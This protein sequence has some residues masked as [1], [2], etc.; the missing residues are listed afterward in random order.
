MSKIINITI[1][2]SKFKILSELEKSLFTDLLKEQSLLEKDSDKNIYSD[3]VYFISKEDIT[4][5]I[6]LSTSLFHYASPSKSTNIDRWLCIHD[7]EEQFNQQYSYFA[8]RANGSLEYKLNT[9]LRGNKNV[10]VTRQK[11][12]FSG[13]YSTQY[14]ERDARFLTRVRPQAKIAK[15]YLT[16]SIAVQPGFGL[17]LQE[18]LSIDSVLKHDDKKSSSFDRDALTVLG[19]IW[20]AA[21]EL[22]WLFEEHKILHNDIK[23]ENMGYDYV[24]DRF[25]FFDFDLSTTILD[26][27]EVRAGS[28]STRAPE[29]INEGEGNSIKS[30]I[31]SLAATI[32]MIVRYDT[33]EDEHKKIIM[34]VIK[35]MRSYNAADRPNNCNELM[36][37]CEFIS[38]YEIL[39]FNKKDY[40]DL[41]YG[42]KMAAK[43]YITKAVD[44]IV[45]RDATV[46]SEDKEQVSLLFVNDIMQNA[47]KYRGLFVDKPDFPTDDQERNEAILE[48]NIKLLYKARIVEIKKELQDIK[49]MAVLIYADLSN[50]TA[51]EAVN[52]FDFYSV[53][54]RVS[55]DGEPLTNVLYKYDQFMLIERVIA[56]I[57]IIDNASL[58]ENEKIKL[59]HDLIEKISNTTFAACQ[60]KLS[61]NQQQP[62]T[63]KFV[64]ELHH[65]NRGSYVHFLSKQETALSAAVCK[66]IANHIDK[67]SCHFEVLIQELSDK[68]TKNRNEV[69][70]QNDIAHIDMISS[71]RNYKQINLNDLINPN[72]LDNFYKWMGVDDFTAE[73]RDDV[74]AIFKSKFYEWVNNID[75][76]CELIITSGLTVEQQGSIFEIFKDKF[77]DWVT[78]VNDFVELYAI[79]NLTDEQRSDIF[80]LFKDKFSDWVTNVND[81]GRLITVRDLT[82]KQRSDIFKLFKDKFSDWVTNV[83]NFNRLI[84]IYDYLPDEQRSDI[85]ELF[86]DKFSD[87]VTNVNDFDRLIAIHYL[88]DEQR[89]DIFKLFKD[90]FSDWVTNV[91]DFGRLITV[92]DLTDKQRSDIFK[93]FKDKFSDWVTNVNNFNRLITIYDLPDEQRS[94][95]FKLFKDKFSDWV[96]N[97]NDF[98]RLI[99]VRDLTDK[100][101]SDIFKLFKDKFSDWVT[102]INDFGR[103]IA[104]RDL[105]DEQRSDI[106]ELFK[107]KFSEWVTN[108]NNFDRLIAIHYLTDEQRSN[109]FD[110][111]KDK[112][113]NLTSTA[114]GFDEL[115]TMPYLTSKQRSYIFEFLKNKFSEIATEY[116]IFYN[117]IKLDLTK[118]QR[119]NLIGNIKEKIPN[120]IDTFQKAKRFMSL[121]SQL[122]EEEELDEQQANEV[123]TELKNKLPN[124]VDD[125][126]K[127]RELMK[128]SFLDEQQKSEIFAILKDE[129]P[130]FTNHLNDFYDIIFNSGLAEHQ[131]EECIAVFKESLP[132]YVSNKD[133]FISIM[134]RF[135]NHPC[136]SKIFDVLKNQLSNYTEASSDLAA[137]M[138]ADCLSEYKS[139]IVIAKLSS[140]VYGFVNTLSSVPGLAAQALGDFIHV[141]ADCV[142]QPAHFVGSFFS[143]TSSRRAET[144]SPVVN[145]KQAEQQAR[146]LPDDEGT[147]SDTSDSDNDKPSRPNHSPTSD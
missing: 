9:S 105:T 45:E 119:N 33:L 126:K 70:K 108:V 127:F 116:S 87:W 114:N 111:L 91:K 65:V 85:F 27:R 29:V 117:L 41:S 136:K 138:S 2:P 61:T 106:F 22:N 56:A 43:K 34:P 145:S 146:L 31:Y 104:I 97:V 67:N 53:I 39:F 44:S 5:Q 69:S 128:A 141:I 71:N 19:L 52:Q 137:L 42:T 3:R 72:K 23:L 93:L 77:S 99:T 109:I 113:T 84:A 88:T 143:R 50:L 37:M 125:P 73:Q 130:S 38:A 95:I 81:F 131:Q 124:L 64:N 139:E 40:D 18:Y 120:L 49:K 11:G 75:D 76:F 14:L 54:G 21:A 1:N 25:G 83:N 135:N 82:D 96:T 144:S 134:E 101:R 78:N 16:A 60:K 132:S 107:D 89:S 30:D 62:I 57:K 4:Y 92:R 7:F 10:S 94:D 122:V 86:K 140:T 51:E 32:E 35:K 74:F 79:R 12:R 59:L 98:G 110:V 63:F 58:S 20:R 103:L 112:L 66:I 129:L 6:R 90:K 102:D 142:S 118:E 8:L 47:R 36:H 46:R 48:K 17:N 123:F 24:N 147:N 133:D 13:Y 26:G 28:R 115:L 121:L 55:Q 68:E 80:K 100:Q 15:P